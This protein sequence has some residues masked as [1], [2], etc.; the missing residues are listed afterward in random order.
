VRGKGE[1]GKRPSESGAGLSNDSEWG[2]GTTKA[3]NGW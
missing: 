3:M 1:E 2:G